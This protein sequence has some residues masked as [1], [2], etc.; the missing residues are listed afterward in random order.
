MKKLMFCLLMLVCAPCFG[1]RSAKD[2]SRDEAKQALGYMTN[3][4]TLKA[5]MRKQPTSC[6]GSLNPESYRA[7]YELM[8]GLGKIYNIP[9]VDLLDFDRFSVET[10][11]LPQYPKPFNT[12]FCLFTTS[13]Y[14]KDLPG[15]L[16]EATE[17][18]EILRDDLKQPYLLFATCKMMSS[19]FTEEWVKEQE[20]ILKPIAEKE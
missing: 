15:E 7:R 5:N 9:G 4:G 8:Q 12:I 3:F 11:N 13:D 10:T 1:M 17:Y 18:S 16:K 6:G 20:T 19:K 2:F 14:F